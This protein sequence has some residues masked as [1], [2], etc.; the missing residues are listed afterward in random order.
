[1]P[2]DSQAKSQRQARNP[3]L[4]GS[5]PHPPPTRAGQRDL[6]FVLLTTRLHCPAGVEA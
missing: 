5:C 4:M 2:K 6:E 1:M 3:A